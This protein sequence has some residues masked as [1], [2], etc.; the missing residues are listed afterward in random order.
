MGVLTSA[1][2][3]GASPHGEDQL[4][5]GAILDGIVLQGVVVLQLHGLPDEVLLRHRDACNVPGCSHV[6]INTKYV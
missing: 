6:I 2:V 4:E 5:G 1:C 3:D